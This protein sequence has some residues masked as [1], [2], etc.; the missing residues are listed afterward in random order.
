[1]LAHE[2]REDAGIGGEAGERDA[3]V[4]VDGDDLLLVGGKFFCVALK[5]QEQSQSMYSVEAEDGATVW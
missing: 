4:G 3:V 5:V 1:M 2:V